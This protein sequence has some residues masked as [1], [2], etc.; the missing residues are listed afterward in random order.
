MQLMKDARTAS[1]TT[2][3]GGVYSIQDRLRGGDLGGSGGV[4]GGLGGSGG[5]GGR[6]GITGGKPLMLSHTVQCW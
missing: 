5:S 6:G 4:A 2:A 3:R 1:T